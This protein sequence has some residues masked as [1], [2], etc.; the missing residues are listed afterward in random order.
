MNS[1]FTISI[2]SHG[3]GAL[4]D[5][6][7]SDLNRQAGSDHPT[8]ILTYNVPENPVSSTKYPQLRIL[9]IHNE[10]PSG[11]GANHNAAFAKCDTRWFAVLNPDLRLPSEPFSTLLAA[12]AEAER[13]GVIAPTVVN[14]GGALEDAVR[15][16]LTPLSLL[17]RRALGSR[18]PHSAT[19]S[20]SAESFFWIAGMFMLF[21][22]DVFR[23]VGGFD[24]RFFLYCEDYD[25]CARLHLA[26]YTLLVDPATRVV[27]DAQRDSHRSMKHMRLHLTSLLK[28]W[29]SSAFW[30]ITITA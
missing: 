10:R 8:V 21:P 27:H 19:D 15:K 18:K 28:V 14:S 22:S 2:V 1:D 4:L 23:A 30:R 24:E 5:R 13:P 29:M 6:L 25:I 7:L 20:R 3:H 11:F 16:N 26:G 12:A 17:L 9:S